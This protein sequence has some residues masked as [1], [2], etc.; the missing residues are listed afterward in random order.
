MLQIDLIA[1]SGKAALILGGILLVV[2]FSFHNSSFLRGQLCLALKDQCDTQYYKKYFNLKPIFIK[3][4]ITRITNLRIII[5]YL[6]L[7]VQIRKMLSVNVLSLCDGSYRE[8]KITVQPQKHM[9][10]FTAKCILPPGFSDAVLVY[11]GK[12]TSL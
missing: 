5:L 7:L 4:E 6:S 2:Y 11:E 8:Q 12:S 9:A 10:F 3:L 1:P